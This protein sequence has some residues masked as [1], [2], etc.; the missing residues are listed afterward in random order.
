MENRSMT[1]L[2]SAFARA[3]HFK[4]EKHPVF[5]D[6]AAEKLMTE[7]EYAG[8][9]KYVRDGIDF[10][11]PCLRESFRTARRLDIS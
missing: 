3:Y 10:L 7:E 6:S 1:A 9:A 11:L 5:A 4:T 2:M 8:I